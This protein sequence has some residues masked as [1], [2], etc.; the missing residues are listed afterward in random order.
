M[1]DNWVHRSVGMRC[2]SCVAFVEKAANVTQKEDHMIG[3]CRRNAPTM[4][5]FPV[6]FSDDWC[7]Q[8]KLDENK[9]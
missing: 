8:H 2:G 3:R 4:Y 9:V 6:V 5:G 7:C 1:E